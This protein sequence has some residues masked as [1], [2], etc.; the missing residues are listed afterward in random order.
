MKVYLKR[1]AILIAIFFVA[2]AVYFIWFQKEDTPQ[3]LYTS[4]EEADFPTVSIQMLGREMN[5]LHGYRT[6]MDPGASRENLTVLPEDRKLGI[7]I[8]KR[9]KQIEG[10]SYEIRSLDGERLI[11]RT[12]VSDLQEQ[13]DGRVYAVLPIQNLLTEGREYRLSIILHAEQ[14]SKL[15]YTTRIVQTKQE[16]VQEMVDLAISFSDRTFDPERSGELVTYLESDNSADT[17]SLGHVTIHSSFSQITWGNMQVQRT[18]PVY[19]T[20]AELNGS[21]ATVKLRYLVGEES[22][23]GTKT[24]EVIEDFTMR[25]S[26]QRIYMMDYNRTMNQIFEGEENLFSGKRILLG[27]SDGSNLQV[28]SSPSKQYTVFLANRE[29]W[30][31]DSKNKRAYKIFSFRD[32]SEDELRNGFEQ[33]GIKILRAS[34]DGKTDFLVYGYMNRGEHEGQS[35]ITYYQYDHDSRVLKERFFILSDQP[36][37][38]LKEDIERLTYLSSQGIFYLYYD[39]GIY[40][41]DLT[42]GEYLV[43]ADALTDDSFCVSQ[44]KSMLAWQS[45]TDIAQCNLINLMNLETGEKREIFKGEE[46]LLR[47]LGFVGND[48]VY[49]LAHLDDSIYICGQL[50]EIPMYALEVADAQ[51]TVEAHYEKDNLYLTDVLV[52]GSRIHMMRSVKNESGIYIK[53]DEDT[54]VS[55]EALEEKTENGI[56]WYSSEEQGRVYFVSLPAEIAPDKSMSYQAP[57][58]VE[59]ERVEDLILKANN[60]V[61]SMTFYA[62]AGGHMLGEYTIFSDAVKM[63]YDHMGIVTDQDQNVL[64]IRGSRSSSKTIRNPMEVFTQAQYGIE[65]FTGSGEYEEGMLLLDARDCTLEQVLFYVDLGYP[66]A[67]I[68]DTGKMMLIVGYDSSSVQIISLDTGEI[69]RFAVETVQSDFERWGNNY[70]CLFFTN[71]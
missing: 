5:H 41:I 30:S 1:A 16:Q 27:V 71:T 61:G 44:D 60:K 14:L 55:N 21:L 51:T 38:A 36:Y 56:G 10:L 67:V 50:S 19:T 40:G 64:W 31:Y 9:E 25:W 63:A 57:R 58:K 26:S 68:E 46:I 6:Q 54:L 59:K 12:E 70:I 62:Y 13:E 52:D 3:T 35:G 53:K 2:I 8:E 18:S 23:T 17:A 28:I 45:H 66:V 39:H 29:L 69:N 4:L 33:H 48:V 34:D 11:E 24:Y 65:N 47:T 42:S 32:H 22:E 43:I 7:Y 49:G 15:Y 20:L 37:E